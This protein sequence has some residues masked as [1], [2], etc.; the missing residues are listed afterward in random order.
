LTVLILPIKRPGASG[1]A[2]PAERRTIH[3]VPGFLPEAVDQAAQHLGM[4]GALGGVYRT[5]A[6]LVQAGWLERGTIKNPL[7]ELWLVPLPFSAFRVALERLFRFVESEINGTEL[8][9][10]KPISVPPP[11]ARALYES[12]RYWV[13]IPFIDSTYDIQ[14]KVIESAT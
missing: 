14:G 11:I 4:I 13:N 6:G 3:V 12:S 9:E 1:A 7:R 5:K 8:R 2:P 10:L